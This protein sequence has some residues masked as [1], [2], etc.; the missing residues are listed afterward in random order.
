M[1]VR[2]GIDT[3]GTF[4]DLVAVDSSSGQAFQAKVPSTPSAPVDAVL[5]ALRSAEVPLEEVEHVV[6]GTTVGANALIE[7]RGAT[8]AYL[9]TDGFE[10]IPFIQRGNRPYHYDLHWRKPRPFIDR[11]QCIGVR[12]R[13]DSRG[14]VIAELTVEEQERIVGALA[15]TAATDGIEAI[16]V[17]LLFGYIHPRHERLLGA[18]LAERLP[19]LAVSL[20]HEVA[21]VWREYER[22]LTTIADAYLKPQLAGFASALEA[23]L[24]EMGVHGRCSLLRSNGGTQ[25]LSRAAAAPVQLLLSGMAGGVMA[26]KRF[27][28]GVSESL[29]TL[30]MGGT[31][32][33][34][35][36]I[37]ENEH[38]MAGTYEIEFGLPLAISAI[39]VS[40]IGAGGGSIASVDPGG[41][42]RVGPRS[43][44]AEPGPACYARGGREPTVTDA[45]LALGRIDAEYFLGGAVRLDRGAAMDSLAAL[46]AQI[47]LSALE[48]ALAVVAIANEGMVDAIR[49]RTVEVGVDPR[50]HCLV[51][52]G[53]AGP[54]HAASIARALGIAKVLVPPRPGLGSAV[55]AL[56]ADLRSDQVA[57]VHIRSEDGQADELAERVRQLEL[58]ALGEVNARSGNGGEARTSTSVALRY[59]GQNYEHSI[60]LPEG[61]VTDATLREAFAR[62]EALHNSFYGYD[63]RGEVIELTDLTVTAIVPSEV[64][65]PPAVRRLYSRPRQRWVHMA[66]EALQASVFRR[67]SL[68]P[69]ASVEG[70]AIVEDAD[71]TTLIEGG[72][73]LTVLTDGSLLLTVAPEG[74]S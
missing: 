13:I 28:L 73:R 68:Q 33:D 16:A 20:S 5:A 37:V 46:G 54:L 72:D 14:E 67:E 39:D 57:T 55:G 36:V 30:D 45:N 50:S 58:R 17:S 44:G 25:P 18:V 40:T 10:D 42:V 65:P 3:G 23:G 48:A 26:G 29:I 4:T 69:G 56:S 59:A 15:A 21:P 7:R 24:G 53:G 49:V 1:S 43:A 74:G 41:F 11:W 35:A 61:P 9:T 52:F 32:C 66:G 19:S 12:E 6:L 34:I 51:A 27:G 31:S 63:L 60:D 2:V 22:G 47:G 71:A 38:R 64:Q 70:P 62:F 8:V